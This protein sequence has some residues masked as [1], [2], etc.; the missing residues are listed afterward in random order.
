MTNKMYART[1]SQLKFLEPFHDK[2]GKLILI[3][4]IL[5]YRNKKHHV[6]KLF[7]LG[8]RVEVKL[9][10]HS[11]NFSVRRHIKV[12]NIRTGKIYTISEPD[13]VS[14]INTEI[15]YQSILG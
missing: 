6:E 14:R 12:K 7:V 10:S 5:N 1:E 13:N 3:G 8:F 4:D 15:N 2:D 11:N 9:N